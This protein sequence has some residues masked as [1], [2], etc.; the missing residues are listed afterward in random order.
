[1]NWASSVSE[2]PEL[3]RAVD[4]CVAALREGLLGETPD[5]LIGFVSPH[6]AAAHQELPGRLQAAFPGALLLGCGGQSVIGSG[7]ELEGRP[8][9]ALCAAHL[10]GVSLSPFHLDASDVATLGDT[11]EHWPTLVGAQASEDPHFILLGDPFSG[12]VEALA[13]SLDAS[14][15]TSVKVGGLASGAQEPG[16]SALFLGDEIHRSGFVGLALHGDVQVDAIVAQGCRPVGDPMFVTHCR[17]NVLHAV[18]GR[19]PMEVLGELFARADPGERE[20]LQ[21]ALFLGIEMVSDR[22]EYGQGDFLIRNLTGGDP[23]GGALS[24][25]ASLHDTQ[26]VQFHVRDR[27]AAAEDLAR[28]LREYPGRHASGALLFSCLGRGEALYGEP[29]HDSRLFA[30]CLGSVPLTGFFCNGEIGPVQDR[31]FLHSYTSAFGI[32]RPRSVQ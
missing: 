6:H 10:P 24:V 21:H 31:T 7:R 19:Q 18:D 12:D 5:L 32:F 29:D 4:E 27:H 3:A 23:D 11:P 9:L 30:E 26:V 15:P 1:M 8:G 14:F 16:E 2:R 13:Q 17:G 22:T 28:R 25:A 20:L